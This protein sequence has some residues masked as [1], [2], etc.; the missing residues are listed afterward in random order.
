MS[1]FWIRQ[2]EAIIGNRSFHSNDFEM[3]FKVEFDD[4]DDPNVSEVKIYNLS[5]G[6]ISSMKKDTPVILNAGYQG[7]VG[8]ILQG[9][10]EKIS[11]QVQGV[12]KITTITVGEGTS[13]W[14]N[15]EVNK[16]YAEGTK[17]SFIAKDIAR[18]FGMEIGEIRLTKDIEYPRGKV[19]SGATQNILRQIAKETDSK[20]HITKGKIYIRPWD[21]GDNIGFLLNS[22]TGLIDSP[23]FFE[24]EEG[25]G[26]KAR[27][28]SGYK[29][30]M[31]LNHRITTDSIIQLDSNVVNGIFRVRK[32]THSGEF[33]TEVE[34][35]S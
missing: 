7:D 19:V 1:K 3:E 5:Q 24:E 26:D 23:E 11:S 18:E 33:T 16:T 10:I 32:G 4:K 9:T 35:I 29:V 20:L 14:L 30:R 15:S 27:K 28:V 13:N 8:T 21:S 34:V 12:D 17:A 6:T 2:T 22:D 25:S 31:L